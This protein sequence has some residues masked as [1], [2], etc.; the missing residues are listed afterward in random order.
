MRTSDGEFETLLGELAGL[1]E[2]LPVDLK[3]GCESADRLE[4]L[5]DVEALLME[6]LLGAEAAK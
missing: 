3:E 5:N 6:R 4:L 2:F 1:R